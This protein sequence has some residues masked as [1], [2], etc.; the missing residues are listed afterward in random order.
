MPANSYSPDP[1]GLPKRH[2]GPERLSRSKGVDGTGQD[3]N[4][5][6]MATSLVDEVIFGRSPFHGKI[7]QGNIGGN[8]TINQSGE[9]AAR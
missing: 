2:P 3:H 9:F 4:G 1:K 6:Q 7:C 8:F 5:R